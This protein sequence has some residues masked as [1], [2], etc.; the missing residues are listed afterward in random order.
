MKRLRAYKN[1]RFGHLTLVKYAK[2]GGTGIGAYWKALCDCGTEVEVLAR[3]VSAGRIL[4]CGKCQY[5]KDLRS[6][7]KGS[8]GRY[9]RD[10]AKLL[11]KAGDEGTKVTITGV[12]F[13]SYVHQDCAL[14]G[15]I[16]K[17]TKMSIERIDTNLEYTSNNVAVI[18]TDCR[19]MKGSKS[20]QEL[21]DKVQQIT[22][23][24]TSSTPK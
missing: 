2:A 18:C 23:H 22:N 14:C 11:G 19:V 7:G 8:T 3:A 10:Y 21:I 5:H 6:F 17:G 20:L 13:Q 12:Q 1:K 15:R 24:L 16:A 4:T 9:R